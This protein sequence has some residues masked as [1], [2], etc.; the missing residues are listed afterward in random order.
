MTHK[1]YV[2]KN[3][4]THRWNF[5]CN[6]FS[7]IIIFTTCTQKG[8]VKGKS[9]FLNYH[10]YFRYVSFFYKFYTSKTMLSACERKPT[11]RVNN[12]KNVNLFLRGK[13]KSYYAILTKWINL[14][15]NITWIKTYKFI[16][17]VLQ[18][19]VLRPRLENLRAQ[20]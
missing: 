12:C 7:N 2:I 4:Y 16:F 6:Y 5:L 19:F 18:F 13:V 1:L 17:S 15:H 9:C 14:F 20:D 3:R 8:F 11:Q 10:I